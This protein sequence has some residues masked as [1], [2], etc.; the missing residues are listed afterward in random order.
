[1]LTPAFCSAVWP[2][3]A[4]LPPNARTLPR[5]RLA[6]GVV[7]PPATVMHGVRPRVGKWFAVRECAAPQ[8][9]RNT[10]EVRMGGLGGPRLPPGAG[11]DSPHRQTVALPTQ[12]IRVWGGGNAN[13]PHPCSRQPTGH[14]DM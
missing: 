6:G 2:F 14:P 11:A 12:P 10:S 13:Q 9:E 8:R 7:P 1:M 4:R 3:S 5:G